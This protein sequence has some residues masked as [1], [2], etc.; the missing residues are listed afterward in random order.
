MYEQA[1]FHVHTY[2]CGHAENISDE[3]YIQKAIE[4]GADSI[5]FADHA[6]FPGD[7]FGSRMK[8]DQLDEYLDTLTGL[9]KKYGNYVHVGLETEYFPSFDKEG[10]YKKLRDDKRIE[11]LLLGQHMAEDPVSGEYTFSWSKERLEQEEFIALGHAICHGIDSGYFDFIAH[12]DRIYRHCRKWT[13]TMVE[14][15]NKIIAKAQ[16]CKIP[17]ELNMSSLAVKDYYWPRF[18][19]MVSNRIIGL[20]AHSIQDLKG[21]FEKQ[22]KYCIF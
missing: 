8:Y 13:L 17:L 21:G 5:W 12:P 6:P 22:K 2:R 20:D 18:W 14:V 9:K 15:G 3:A 19:Q 11:F 1:A 4:I 7:P 10:Y 16:I